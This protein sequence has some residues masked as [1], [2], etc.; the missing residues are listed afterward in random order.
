[1][2][3]L[4]DIF[5]FVI[6]VNIE[7]IRDANEDEGDIYSTLVAA[8]TFRNALRKANN[9]IT[10][11]TQMKLLEGAS[12][13]AKNVCS[14]WIV[15]EESP[16]LKKDLKNVIVKWKRS[17]CR[18]SPEYHLTHCTDFVRYYLAQACEPVESVQLYMCRLSGKARS[19][20]LKGST[21]G[22]FRLLDFD[23]IMIQSIDLP[24]NIVDVITN[25]LL[26]GLL[27]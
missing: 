23:P 22:N 27:L 6:H 8:N 26:E 21:H 19:D 20:R 9:N 12:L 1:M 13:N 10:K 4:F 17:D 5:P 11:I 2:S 25:C 24:E 16:F 15:P 14:H 18:S 3:P 7:Q